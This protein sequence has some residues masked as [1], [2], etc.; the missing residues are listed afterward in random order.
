MSGLGLAFASRICAATSAELVWSLFR[1]F[2][3]YTRGVRV[4]IV[5][6]MGMV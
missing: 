3:R 5:Q 6:F 4:R 1:T 2:E